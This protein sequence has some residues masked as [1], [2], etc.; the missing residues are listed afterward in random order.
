MLRRHW[1][2]WMLVPS[3]LLL[4]FLLL[5]LSVPY[6]TQIYRPA[7]WPA[8]LWPKPPPPIVAYNRAMDRAR[9]A[10]DVSNGLTHPWKRHTASVVDPPVSEKVQPA[11]GT[12]ITTTTTEVVL[13]HQPTAS[14]L[15]QPVLELTWVTTMQVM[16]GRIQ[17]MEWHVIRQSQ[18]DIPVDQQ[19]KHYLSD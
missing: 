7:W 15:H 10:F 14:S 1:K 5:L 17:P 18:V 13:A 6:V 3:A 9:R 19:V 16:E 8:A 11:D 4:L 12:I 2:P